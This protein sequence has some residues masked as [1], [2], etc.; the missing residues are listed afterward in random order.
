M[1]WNLTKISLDVKYLSTA[2]FMDILSLILFNIL[3]NMNF[4]NYI[5]YSIFQAISILIFS[6]FNQ[7]FIYFIRIFPMFKNNAEYEDSKKY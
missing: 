7:M 1:E 4:E 3:E 6:V 2:L 5:V